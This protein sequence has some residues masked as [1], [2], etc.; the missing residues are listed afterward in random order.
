MRETLGLVLCYLLVGGEMSLSEAAEPAHDAASGAGRQ[1]CRSP[2]THESVAEF[3]RD[4][5]RGKLSTTERG[6]G[7]NAG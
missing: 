2:R 4:V 7:V 1:A 5:E 6:R 3:A